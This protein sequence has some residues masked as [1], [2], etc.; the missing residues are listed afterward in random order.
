M[1]PGAYRLGTMD[2][3]VEATS[4][5]LRDGRLAGSIIPLDAAV[6]NVRAFTGA[7]V[8]EAV[9][10]VTSTPARLLGLAPGRVVVRE[11]GA[12]DLTILNPELEV[13][14]TVV[15][16]RVVYRAESG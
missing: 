9:R 6:R 3:V 7:T 15:A 13:V 16:G 1:A 11:G 4:A 12:A 14:A 8:A 5:R 10:T 2:L